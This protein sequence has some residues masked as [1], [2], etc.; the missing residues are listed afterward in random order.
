MAVLRATILTGSQK[1]EMVRCGLEAVPG[2]EEFVEGSELRVRYLDGSAADLAHEVFVVV[3]ERDVPS[4][5]PTVAQRDAVDQPD[6]GQIFEDP[7]DGRRLYPARTISN[8]VDDQPCADER[9]VTRHQ[10]A[11]HGPSGKGQAESGLP[12]PL[13]QQVFGHDDIIRHGH[14]L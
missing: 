14:T 10:S 6:P 13:D 12:D 9:L 5:R 4:S 3:V 8:V 1:S 2:V 7:V 11:N